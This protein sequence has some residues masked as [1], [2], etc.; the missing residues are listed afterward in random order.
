MAGSSS[1]PR[2]AAGLQSVALPEGDNLFGDGACG[3]GALSVVVMRPCSNR[4]VTRLRKVARRCQIAS[5][6]RIPTSKSHG[7]LP[8]I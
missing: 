4:L 3:L 7:S 2:L 5:Q 6:F 1:K 8:F